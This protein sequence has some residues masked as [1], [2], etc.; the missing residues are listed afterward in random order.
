M[1]KG[2]SEKPKANI[3]LIGET[4]NTFFL[5]LGTTQGSVFLPLLF[6]IVL[7]VLASAIRQVRVIKGIHIGKEEI[8]L[9]FFIDEI[10]KIILTKLK[11][12]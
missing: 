10:L 2:I 4:L 5:S 7:L 11:Y 3:L 6:Y 12:W 1:I 9:S 8:R